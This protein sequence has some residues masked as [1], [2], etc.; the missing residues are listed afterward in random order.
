MG[1]VI[2]DDRNAG[3]VHAVEDFALG[4]GYGLD[5]SEFADMRRSRVVDQRHARL[6]NA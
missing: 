3:R 4:A 5:G 2:V 1:V 6:R